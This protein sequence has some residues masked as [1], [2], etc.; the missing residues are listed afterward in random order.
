MNK[1]KLIKTVARK[2]NKHNSEV[3]DVLDTALDMIIGELAEGKTVKLVGFGSFEVR[4][5]AARTGRNPRTGSDIHIPAT[6]T[7]AF[8]AGKKLR[9][10]VKRR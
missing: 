4:N 9:D 3:Q 10:A 1:D 6:K 5:R 2:L 7:P 8:S